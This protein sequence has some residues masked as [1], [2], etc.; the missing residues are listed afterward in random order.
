MEAKLPAQQAA[1]P[2]I[3]ASVRIMSFLPLVQTHHA[4]FAGSRLRHMHVDTTVGEWICYS[5]FNPSAVPESR[6]V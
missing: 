4:A 6:K 3:L 2:A 5:V 1:V